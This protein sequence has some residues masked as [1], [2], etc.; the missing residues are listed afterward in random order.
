MNNYPTILSKLKLEEVIKNLEYAFLHSSSSDF[1]LF[2]HP[3][4]YYY[5]WVKEF[6]ENDLSLTE[7]LRTFKDRNIYHSVIFFYGYKISERS[8]LKKLYQKIKDSSIAFN[9]N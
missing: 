6:N 4:L 8:Y 3:K 5:L 1:Y 9:L 2:Y 7:E